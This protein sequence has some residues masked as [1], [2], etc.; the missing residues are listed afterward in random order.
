VGSGVILHYDGHNWQEQSVSPSGFELRAVW[1]FDNNHIVAVGSEGIIFYYNGISWNRMDIST[2][3]GATGRS[4]L[5]YAVWGSSP[6]DVFAAG[7]EGILLHYDGTLWQKME[8]S[9][10]AAG[11]LPLFLETVWGASGDDVLA[12]GY[13]GVLLH[14]DGQKWHSVDTPVSGPAFNDLWGPLNTG[15][16][17]DVFAVG[18]SGEIF[19]YKPLIQ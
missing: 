3:V 10:G 4:P 16:G 5:L 11:H 6:T 7:S 2:I 13:G 8:N 1:G 14:Y 15:N 17:L 19:R 12:A 9:A 18:D